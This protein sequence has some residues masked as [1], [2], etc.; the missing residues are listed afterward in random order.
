MDIINSY[1]ESS[2][3]KNLLYLAKPVYGGWVTFTAHL[4]HK[5][6]APIYKIAQR[7]ETFDREYGYECK[8][9]NQ[10]IGEIIKLNN[11]LITAVDKH[12]WEYL[13]LLPK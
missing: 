10:S 2:P 4:S 6:N 7:N 8:Y 11:I 3:Q 5:L 9:R 12:Y 1:E 13:H